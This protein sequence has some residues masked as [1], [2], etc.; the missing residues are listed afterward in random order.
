M[1]QEYVVVGYT[2]RGGTT[3][4]VGS[5]LLAAYDGSA[6]RILGKVGTGCRAALT[7]AVAGQARNTHGAHSQPPLD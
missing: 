4:A 5:L 1:R 3:N 7:R 2:V 6:L